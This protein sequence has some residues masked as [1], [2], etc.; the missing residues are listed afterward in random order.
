MFQITTT[1]FLMT[2]AGGLFLL[3][4]VSLAVGISLLAT[5]AVGQNTQII[6]EQ[7][8]KLAEKG[9][10]DDVS[11]LVGNA[12]SLITA[13]DQLARTT[14]GIGIFLIFIGMLLMTASYFLV[15]SL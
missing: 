15:R 1:N 8:K 13:L 9:I 5:K 12:S 10:A 11:G 14:A 2:M 3:G 4:L 6:A 7:T